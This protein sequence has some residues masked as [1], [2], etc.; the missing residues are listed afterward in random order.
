MCDDERCREN[1]EGIQLR[2]RFR[3]HPASNQIRGLEK[4]VLKDGK[5]FVTLER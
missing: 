2:V 3:C 4:L 5:W 1:D